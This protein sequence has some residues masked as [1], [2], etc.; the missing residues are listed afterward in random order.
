MIHVE[1][2][3]KHAAIRSDPADA[4]AAEIDAVI[5]PG[6]AD[7]TGL[8]GLGAMRA[9]EGGVSQ[10]IQRLEARPETGEHTACDAG[11]APTR[12]EHRGIILGKIG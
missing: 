7:Q 9:A 11:P 8:A 10:T 5:G 3:A 1:A 12:S 4:Q 2:G 6:A